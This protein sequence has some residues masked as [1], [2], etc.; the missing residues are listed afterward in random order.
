MRTH[1]AER[2]LAATVDGSD[3]FA[4]NDRTESQAPPRAD[5][6]GFAESLGLQGLHLRDRNDV[7]PA[8]EGVFPTARPAVSNV[9]INPGVPPSSPHSILE[10]G[11]KTAVAAANGDDCAWAVV[12]E[13]INTKIQ[14]F[15][16]H[17]E[18]ER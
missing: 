13:G 3:W 17:K 4:R 11:R 10:Q 16:P 9:R 7:G 2:A 1:H 6:A 12:R 18:D 15:L 5:D 14:E 8:W